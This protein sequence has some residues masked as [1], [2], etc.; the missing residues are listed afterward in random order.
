MSREVADSGSGRIF[1][2]TQFVGETASEYKSLAGEQTRVGVQAQIMRHYIAAAGVVVQPERV[3]RHRNI[4]ALA[5]RSARRLGKAPASSGPQN[6]AFAGQHTHYVGPQGFIVSHR[7]A[8]GK[9]G[10]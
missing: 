9:V 1:G 4:L 5:L 10:V 3:V 7:Q 8:S 6:I 2:L